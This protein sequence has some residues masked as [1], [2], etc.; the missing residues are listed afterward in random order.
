MTTTP[1]RSHGPDLSRIEQLTQ[2]L[3]AALGLPLGAELEDLGETPRRVAS[4][5]R[6][7]LAGYAMDPALI[8]GELLSAHHAPAKV[9]TSSIITVRPIAFRSTCQPHL[10]PFFGSVKIAYSPRSEDGVRRI[11]GLGRLAQLVRCFAQRL[12]MQERIGEQI[13]SALIQHSHAEGAMV[14][15]RARHTCAC[16]QA[17]H[18][19]VT[20]ASELI[21]AGSLAAGAPLHVT[22]VKMLDPAP[23]SAV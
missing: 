14:L 10:M 9:V 15:I 22:A 20:E 6:E 7:A 3:L 2:D 1:E 11:I 13:A 4:A 19:I 21:A 16:G 12:S 23:R 8:L 5:W 17:A 18:Q